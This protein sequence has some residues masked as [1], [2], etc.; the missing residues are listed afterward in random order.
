MKRRHFLFSSAAA[1]GLGLAGGLQSCIKSQSPGEGTSKPDA[2]TMPEYSVSTLA[3]MFRS[4][5]L[6]PR[7]VAELFLKRI[8]AIDKS[9][10]YLN[11]VIELN[12]D[13]LLDADRAGKELK[14]GIDR[15]PFH[16]IPLLIKDNIDTADKMHTTAG[17]LALADSI[18]LEDAGIVARLRKAGAVILGKTNLSEWANIRSSHS[19]SGWSARGGQTRNPYYLDCNPCG[20]SSGSAVAVSSNLCTLAIGTETDG[21]VVCPSSTNGIVGIKPT[22]GLWSRSGIIPISHTQDTAGPM[23]RCVA[24]A[25]VLLGVC[26][27]PDERDQA[28]KACP[29]PENTDFT[30]YLDINGLKGARIGVDRNSFG[31]STAV[32]KLMEQA[33][34]VM[35]RLGAEIIDPAPLNLPREA[36]EAEMEVLMY[37]FKAGL[38]KYLA[39]CSSAVKVRS[40]KDLIRFNE[41]NAEKEMPWFGQELFHLA[42]S[43]GDLDDPAYRK[44]LAGSLRFSRQQGIDR[45]LKAYGLDAIIAPTGGPAWKTDWVN[46]D[47][48]SG[49]SSSASA[50]AGYPAITV[51]AGNI[52]GLPVGITFMGGAWSEPRLISLAFAYEQASGARISPE[53]QA[54]LEG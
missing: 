30:R 31:F 24:D 17:S 1:A 3:K 6:S 39:G 27:G 47:H 20:S 52:H 53:F 50:C 10:P 25:A 23:A 2:M 41:E 54:R 40:L 8:N 38:N 45:T 44:A 35:K 36:G 11:S 26:L 43:K 46:G 37:E 18:A 49:G 42:E 33:I 28:T 21:S 51:P 48:F 14:E 4:G 15:G 13:A 19:S 16:G 7:V 29:F 9:G 22:V 12:P 5:E 34:L 32:D